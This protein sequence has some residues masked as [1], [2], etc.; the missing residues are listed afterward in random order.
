MRSIGIVPHR[1]REVALDIA[2]CAAA[3]LEERGIEVRLPDAEARAARLEPCGTTTDG[4]AEGLDLVI[5]IGGDGTMLRAVQLA[6]P[7]DVPLFGVNVGQMGYLTSIEPEDVEDALPRL[8]AGSY[9]VS[10]RT[11]LELSVESETG[12]ARTWFALNE[13]VLEKVHAGHLVRLDVSIDSTYFTTYA[14][15]GVIVATATGSTAYSFSAR[16]PIASP[17]L[18][19]LIVTPVSPHMLFDRALVLAPEESLGLVVGGSRTVA[20]TMDGRQI[21]ELQ[22]GDACRCATAARAVHMVSLAPRDFHQILKA[23]FALPDR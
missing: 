18:A 13:A 23:K 1:E 6:Y 8:L 11:V 21:A 15:D 10:D 17:N 3:W 4:F 19:C 5:A 9:S 7:G 16:G 22:P 2:R 20:L 14:A 12:Q